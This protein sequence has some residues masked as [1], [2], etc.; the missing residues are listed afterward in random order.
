M[1]QLPAPRA[2]RA[3]PRPRRAL[4]VALA[5]LLL[6]ALLPG[7]VRAGEMAPPNRGDTLL[8]AVDGIKYR[9]DAMRFDGAN[10]GYAFSVAGCGERP[11]QLIG[12]GAAVDGRRSSARLS[13]SRPV[14]G[15]DA[16]ATIVDGWEASGAGSGGPG[17]RAWSIC[18]RS[19][20]IVLDANSEQVAPAGTSARYGSA[21]CDDTTWS[22]VSGGGFIATAG[23]R[24]AST[25]LLDLPADAGVVPDNAWGASM[26]DTV[27]GAGF[28]TAN[29]ICARGPSFRY[30]AGSPR[31][32]PADTVR[33]FRVA[34]PVRTHVVGGGAT[35]EGT[36][37]A[38]RLF[39]SHPYDGPDADRIPD[40][41]WR[42]RLS[43]AAATPPGSVQVWA[44]CL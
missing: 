14:D 11:W 28:A 17:I 38:V 3:A 1:V 20:G 2:R 37:D 16:D 13:A 24:L 39:A 5:G 8:G 29:V 15:P 33:S 7:L 40:D 4:P 12:G 32:L 9:T 31:A 27:G 41:G 18:V 22:A 19:P 26:H 34:C 30:V 25:W 42:V 44:V 6:L 35:V 21:S 23:S 43:R 10:D 36:A